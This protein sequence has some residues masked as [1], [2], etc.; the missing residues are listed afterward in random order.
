MSLIVHKSAIRAYKVGIVWLSVL[1]LIT[2]CAVTPNPQPVSSPLSLPRP[3][4]AQSVLPTPNPSAA[5]ITGKLIRTTDRK[6]LPGLTVF[7]ERTPQ[8]STVPPVLYAPPNDQPRATTNAVGEFT[9]VGV[10]EGEYVVV[11]Y[12]PPVNI[13]VFTKPDSEQPL[14]IE[15]KPGKVINLGVVSIAL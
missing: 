1:I 9:I 15:A 7:V 12:S 2:G 6:P 11:V 14:F 5:T 3:T 8:A 10:P 13:Q 4:V